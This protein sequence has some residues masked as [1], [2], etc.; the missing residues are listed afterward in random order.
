[1]VL[2]VLLKKQK[3][4]KLN[5]LIWERQHSLSLPCHQLHTEE[6]EEEEAKKLSKSGGVL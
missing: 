4:I 6:E 1:V 3:R 5:K 2:K